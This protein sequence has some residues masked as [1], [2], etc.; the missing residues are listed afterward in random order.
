MSDSIT[1]PHCRAEIPLTDAISHQVQERL[2][3]EFATA[4]SEKESE[5][6]QALAAKD[7]ELQTK[8]ADTRAEVEAAA[9]ARAEE[10][11]SAEVADL[12]A[13]LDDKGTR[14]ADAEQKELAL[15]KEK[16]ALEERQEALELEVARKIAEERSALVTSTTERVSEKFRLELREKDLTLEQMD[17]RIEDLRAAADQKRPGLQGEVLEREIEDV[18]R[19]CFPTDAI[20]PV[21]SGKRGADVVQRVRSQRGLD[22]GAVLWE[23]KNAKHWSNAWAEKLKSDQQAE[24]ADIAIIVSS[25]LPETV[26]RMAFHQGVWVCDFASATTLATVLRLALIEIGQARSVDANR[27]QA[28]D[29]LYNYLCGKEFQHRVATTVDAAIALKKDLDAEK[30]AIERQ[31]GK[32]EKQ[33]EH[34]LRNSAGMYG[35]LQAIVGDALQPVPVLELAPGAEHD[36]DEPLALAS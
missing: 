1:C 17:K 33:I 13:Q 27:T 25:V 2:R 15:L 34:L 5:H 32:R 29:A 11:V 3:A 36:G 18:L 26:Q 14:L 24:K 20:T 7:V 8:I 10:D 12:R 28:M 19:E 16:R 6:A 4:L 9:H 22:C 35:E 31:W 30:I 21:K 23:S